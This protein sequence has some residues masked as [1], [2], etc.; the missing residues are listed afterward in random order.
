MI[1][2]ATITN[3]NLNLTVESLTGNVAY[4]WAV[5][6]LKFN[7]WLNIMQKY[8]LI[9]LFSFFLFGCASQPK[10][11]KA[12]RPLVENVV[13]SNY[14]LIPEQYWSQLSNNENYQLKHNS[15]TIL[16]GDFFFSGLGKSCRTLYIKD[17]FTESE[18]N[19]IACYNEEEASWYLTPAIITKDETEVFN[20]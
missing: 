7:Y 5:A 19:R 16:L 1:V 4:Q 11:V 10:Q 2:L 17:E 3:N 15:I 12:S 14:I 20:Q 6:Y 8:P 18:Q 9:F 13:P